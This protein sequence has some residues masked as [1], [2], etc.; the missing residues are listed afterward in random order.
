MKAYLLRFAFLAITGL[1][2]LSL[3]TSCGESDDQDLVSIDNYVDEAV[4]TLEAQGKIGRHG[5]AEFVFP[6]T[7]LFP[8]ENSATVADYEAL[9]TVI[10]EWRENNPDAEEK[11]TL[12]FP[13]EVMTEDGELLTI[14][15]REELHELRKACRRAHYDKPWRRARRF[16]R[17][18]C[19]D[20]A[21]PITVV[22]PDG[23]EL[24][25]ASAVA[26]KNALR[27][28]RRTVQN[29]DGR[30]MIEFPIT[31]EYEDGTTVEV[32]SQEELKD[33]KDQ[34]DDGE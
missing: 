24:E 9:R 32:A 18:A 27:A 8:G 34:C 2:T 23:S 29:P 1:M 13:L 21:F 6:I 15:S 33:L 26:L 19:F 14:E 5:C 31:V 11:P 22:F 25:A 12:E 3:I 17:S 7:I 28:W 4:F 10:R 20:L 30:P 16:F